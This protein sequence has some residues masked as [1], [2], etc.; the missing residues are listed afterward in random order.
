FRLRI[1]Y[2]YVPSASDSPRSES[3]S[4]MRY[5]GVNSEVLHHHPNNGKKPH[6]KIFSKDN[7]FEN[8][9]RDLNRGSSDGKITF[10]VGRFGL[11]GGSSSTR[12]PNIGVFKEQGHENRNEN[13]NFLSETFQKSIEGN[14]TPK[15]LKEGGDRLLQWKKRPRAYKPESRSIGKDSSKPPRKILRTERQMTRP[16]K[17]RVPVEYQVTGNSRSMTLRAC[18]PHREAQYGSIR[19]S[20]EDLNG[21]HLNSG[22]CQRM[23]MHSPAR[24]DKHDKA[25][26][27]FSPNAFG[28]ATVTE[29]MVRNSTPSDAEAHA[30]PEKVNME[31]FEWPRILLSLSRKEKEDDFLTVKGTKLSQ[32]PKKRPKN[33]EKVLQNCFPGSWLSDLTRGRYEVREK[34][35]SKKKPR[36]LKAMESSDSESES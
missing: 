13:E 27:C 20:S 7:N 14:S 26:S 1:K 22:F 11:K 36:G 2:S 19:R 17:Q 33:V 5:Q 10:N 25:V 9:G 3:I 34:K 32:R 28:N 15:A 18:T 30:P 21:I 6:L 35:C 8:G 24:H 23:D 31:T 4:A 29:G 16:E 12:S